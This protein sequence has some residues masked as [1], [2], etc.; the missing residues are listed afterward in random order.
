MGRTPCSDKEQIN[1][2]GPW[3]KEEDELLINY[4]NLHGQGNW[5]SIPKAA[6]LLRCGKSCRLRWTN[7]LRPDL[8]KGN[9]TEE[10]SNLIIHLHSLLGNK[11]SQIATSLPGRTDNEIKNYWKSHLKRYLY[12]LGID[13]VTHKPFKEDTNTTSTPPNTDDDYS[14]DG[15]ADSNSSSGVT[16]EEASPQVNLELSIAPPSQPHEDAASVKP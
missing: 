12:A 10:E 16:I 1:K 7:Y 3:S 5:K 14:A 13:P 4:I 6:G 8:K 2:K 9:F 11:W 15:G